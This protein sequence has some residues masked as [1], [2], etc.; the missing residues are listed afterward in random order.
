MDMLMSGMSGGMDMSSDG[1][2]RTYN[3]KL[4]RGYWYIIAGFVGFVVLCR[5]FEWYQNWDR[6]VNI[7]YPPF[8]DAR[9]TCGVTLSLKH[10]TKPSNRLQQAYA[11]ATAILR[12][13]SYPQITFSI[14]YLSWLSPPSS[15]RSILLLCYWAILIF[16]MTYNVTINDA[17]YFERIGF[18]GAWI[19]VTQVP[20]VYLLAS[21]SNVIGFLMGSSHERLNWFHRWVSRTLLITVTV[22]GSFFLREWIRADFLSFELKMMPMVK[23]GM[24]AWFV[25]LWTFL[26]SLS[27]IRGMAYEIFVMQHIAAAAVFLWLLFMHVPAYAQY[28][29][30][31]AIAAVSFDWILRGV[32][33]VV[34]N[35]RVKVAGA[36]C[37]GM[38]RIGHQAQLQ[39]LS[40]DITIISIKDAPF[41]WKAGQ[42]LYLWLPRLGPLETH[43]FTIASPYQTSDKCHCNEI[44]LAIRAQKGFSRRIHNY[45]SKMQQL[46]KTAILTAFVAGPYGVPPSWSTY[47]TILLISASTGASYTLPILESILHNPAPTCI[48]RI[49]FLL[50]ARHR[51]HIDFYTDRLSAAHDLADKKGIELIVN[52]AVTG[53]DGMSM[54][55]SRVEGKSSSELSDEEKNS[56]G[57]VF[58]KSISDASSI[59]TT[60]IEKG[61]CC[62]SRATATANDDAISIRSAK[63][64]TY[65]DEK[66]DEITPY[67]TIQPIPN[68]SSS[69]STQEGCCCA[70]KAKAAPRQGPSRRNIIYLDGRPEISQFLRKPIEMTGGETAVTVCGGKSLVGKVRNSVAALSDERAVHK[71]TGANGIFLHV[72]EYCF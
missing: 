7:I 26:S 19:S 53:D 29:V 63:R 18:R 34:R 49:Q 9:D 28:N 55:S 64:Q 48:Q 37:R 58:V 50:V 60:P 11:T 30:W 67:T 44:Q 24:G 23:Y 62:N 16:M 6:F 5:G 72:E 56:Q 20:L 71:G 10:P 51:H 22:H 41:T 65:I 21:K 32:L 2:F 45:A 33:L 61:C 35:L 25:L 3:S 57:D 42:H 47:E 4:A 1:M 46:D 69:S 15:G 68:A 17:Y 66:K 27:P 36:A 43:P 39:A 54:T 12:E 59:S 52:I 70:K 40:D 38:Q 14:P 8:V 31:F 13:L